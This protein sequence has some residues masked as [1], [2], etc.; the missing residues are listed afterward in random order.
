MEKLESFVRGDQVKVIQTE[1]SNPNSILSPDR[2]N[3]PTPTR[4][5]INDEDMSDYVL[6]SHR[7]NTSYSLRSQWRNRSTEQSIIS[8][9]MGISIAGGR[10]SPDL[11]D[12][13]EDMDESM[14]SDGIEDL[15]VGR[16]LF[17]DI[18]GEM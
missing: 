15:G 11:E 2:R 10:L 8:S 14:F 5:V 16:E 1:K 3:I 7:N 13:S 4:S 17:A 12:D 6:P 9:S 18:P